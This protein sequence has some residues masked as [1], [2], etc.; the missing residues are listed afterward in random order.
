MPGV[1]DA[2]VVAI[3]YGGEKQLDASKNLAPS[4]DF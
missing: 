2:A 3:D 1:R 4:G